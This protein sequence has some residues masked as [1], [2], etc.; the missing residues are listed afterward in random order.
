MK[1]TIKGALIT[2]LS[3]IVA[4]L[5]ISVVGPIM[6][7]Y[8]DKPSSYNM[9]VIIQAERKAP[10][11][12]IKPKDNKD[13]VQSTKKNSDATPSISSDRPEKAVKEAAATQL[14]SYSRI[15]I[16][17]LIGMNSEDAIE[18]L[19]IVRISYSGHYNG[20]SS[21]NAYV[22][23][24]QYPEAG[25]SVSPAKYKGDASDPSVSLEFV[26]GGSPTQDMVGV[27]E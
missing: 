25:V 14:I 27:I 20:K 5:I 22:V 15:Y 12:T 16:P 6:S 26:P 13:S 18:K 1:V 3:S 7:S 9:K 10:K 8:F 23:S 2:G 11:R 21:N 4:A 24:S 17:N 19:N